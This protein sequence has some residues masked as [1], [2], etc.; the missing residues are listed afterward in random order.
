MYF[1]YKKKKQ[2]TVI[3]I[4]QHK[5]TNGCSYNFGYN[6]LIKS[7]SLSIYNAISQ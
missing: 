1:F 6:W 2:K 4:L 3:N 5:H 7:I